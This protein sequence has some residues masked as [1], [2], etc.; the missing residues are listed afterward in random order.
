MLSDGAVFPGIV[1]SC[2]KVKISCH[3]AVILYFWF[4]AVD[5]YIAAL[6]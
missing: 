2:A 6:L 4:E 3:A 5:D 1:K